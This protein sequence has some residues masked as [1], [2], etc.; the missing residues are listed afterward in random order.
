[1]LWVGLWIVVP[2]YA[3]YCASMRRFY[4]PQKLI[5][6]LLMRLPTWPLRWVAVTIF[7]TINLAHFGARMIYN[8][9]PHVDKVA[10]DVWAANDPRGTLRTYSSIPDGRPIPGGASITSFVG[11]YY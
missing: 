3:F 1:M 4:S 2:T 5:A 7:I 8:V 9:E 6:S 11:K 10:A